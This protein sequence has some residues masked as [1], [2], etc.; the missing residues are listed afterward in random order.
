MI[1]IDS[2]NS[3]PIY[4][5]IV[6]GIKENILRGILTHGERLPSVREMSNLMRITPNTVS[7][8]YME[9][10]RQNVVETIRGKGTFISAEYKPIVDQEKVKKLK[11]NIKNIVVEAHYNGISRDG[12][13]EIIDDVYNE[14][15]KEWD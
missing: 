12:L 3:K 14:I 6:E 10:E 13:I 11:N 15:H 2:R 9:L 7:R 4:E 1:N 5:Q 8:A